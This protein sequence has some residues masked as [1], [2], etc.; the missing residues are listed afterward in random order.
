MS[1][2][3][4]IAQPMTPTEDMTEHTTQVYPT[5]SNTLPELIEALSNPSAEVRISAARMLIPFGPKAISAIPALSRNLQYENSE[6][7]RAAI[8]AL[9]AIGDGARPS[10]PNLIVVLLTDSAVQPRRQSAIALGKIG[11]ASSIP[12]LAQCL[13]DQDL[14]VAA[15]CAESIAVLTGQNFTDLNSSGYSLNNDGVPVIVTEAKT[16]WQDNGRHET[17]IGIGIITPQVPSTPSNSP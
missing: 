10:V 3:S 14:F 6:V 7:R 12:A 13:N 1:S 8:D 11:D 9:G 5:L 16:W 2:C 17:W 4:T 15:L